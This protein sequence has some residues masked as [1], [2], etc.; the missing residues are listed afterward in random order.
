MHPAHVANTVPEVGPQA[1]RTAV[2]LRIGMLVLRSLMS[3]GG[4]VL[5]EGGTYPP[6]L[7]FA[8]FAA[9]PLYAMESRDL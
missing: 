5:P 9:T 8:A 7:Y 3:A 2:W 1:A 4:G 6:P